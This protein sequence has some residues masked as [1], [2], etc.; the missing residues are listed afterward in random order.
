MLYAEQK[1]YEAVYEP[2]NCVGIAIDFEKMYIANWK[3]FP[4]GGSGSEIDI[5]YNNIKRVGKIRTTVY[6]SGN[7]YGRGKWIGRTSSRIYNTL[8]E[9]NYDHE[10]KYFDLKSQFNPDQ[11]RIKGKCT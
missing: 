7:L 3:F 11:F 1:D 4:T 10:T 6:E 9:I 5:R 2:L 8:I